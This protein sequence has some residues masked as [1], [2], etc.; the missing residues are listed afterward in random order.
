[1]IEKKKSIVYS[2]Q[3]S[4]VLEEAVRKYNAGVMC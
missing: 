1:M 2:H 3:F 4:N